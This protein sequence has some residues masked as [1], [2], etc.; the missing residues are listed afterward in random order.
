MG[1]CIPKPIQSMDPAIIVGSTVINSKSVM[2]LDGKFLVPTV[3]TNTG[4]TAIME[5]DI[6]GR[7]INI[8][9]GRAAELTNRFISNTKSKKKYKKAFANCFQQ[10]NHSISI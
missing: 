6:N 9:R 3:D 5:L 2:I 10:D 8:V 1:S 4:E 7:S